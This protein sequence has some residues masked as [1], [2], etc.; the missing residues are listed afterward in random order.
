M[1]T[2]FPSP[3]ARGE[4]RFVGFDAGGRERRNGTAPR[5]SLFI[6]CRTFRGVAEGLA[7]CGHGLA[8]SPHT[9]STRLSRLRLD[10]YRNALE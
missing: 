7:D 6:R 3:V 1:T 9:C 5:A 8:V 4:F 10:R 2:T